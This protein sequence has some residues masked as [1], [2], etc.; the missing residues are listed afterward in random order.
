VMDPSNSARLLLGSN[1]VW[2]TTNANANQPTWA[3]IGTPSP[4]QF[5]TALAIAPSNV[6]HI[7]AATAD[8]H[9]WVNVDG[10][11][12]WNK[13]DNGLSERQLALWWTYVSTRRTQTRSLRS[14]AGQEPRRSGI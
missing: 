9:V 8:G 5:V 2:E 12:Q 14:R 4:N 7:Y 13:L 1:Q 10:G 11:A 3:P 6:K